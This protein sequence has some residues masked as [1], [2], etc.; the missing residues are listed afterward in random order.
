[1]ARYTEDLVTVM[2]LLVGSDGRDCTALNM[3]YYDPRAVNLRDL[4]IAFYTD[5][6]I[7]AADDEVSQTVR[8][9]A[10]AMSDDVALVDEARPTCIEQAYDLEMKL[11]G[12][13]GGDGLW[14]YLEMLES[15]AAHPLLR[16]WLEK[17]VPYR[18]TVAGLQQYWEQWDRYRAQMFAFL[19]DWD[20]IL[21]P[22]YT[23]AALAHGTTVLEENFRGFSHTM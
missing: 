7:A 16:G 10:N 18:T 17:L 5:N 4:R 6:G 23:H 2:P 12:A 11:L 21:C 8:A 15:Q 9:A 19:Q 1:M 3:P 13:D 22:A 20:V 14:Q